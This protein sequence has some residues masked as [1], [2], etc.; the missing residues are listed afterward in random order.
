MLREA[1][2]ALADAGY[3]ESRRGRYGGTFVRADLERRRAARR[4]AAARRARRTCSAC[5]RVLEEGAVAAAAAADRCRGRSGTRSGRG[6]SRRAPPARPTTG[7]PTRGC[8][9]RSAELAGVPS[10]LPLLA[11]VRDRAN[12]LLDSIPLHR[13]EPRPLERA[14]RGDRAGGAPRRP[15]G[16]A[17]ARCGSTS[18]ARPPSS[19]R[20]STDPPR[21][22]ARSCTMGDRGTAS[23]RAP[24]PSSEKEERLVDLDA[25]WFDVNGMVWSRLLVWGVIARADRRRC[26]AAVVSRVFRAVAR[27]RGWPERAVAPPPLAVPLA[28]R[29]DRRLDRV[30]PRRRSARPGTPALRQ[31][32][33]RLLE[34]RDHRHGR[35]ARRGRRL[36]AG[37]PAARRYRTDVADNRVARRVR[38]QALILRRVADRGDRGRRDRAVAAGVPG[39]AGRRAPRC[40]PRPA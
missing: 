28:A 18:R 26:V 14:A 30:R 37:R 34:H 11:D 1:I 19:G 25:F 38:T 6:C 35:L 13:A 36:A 21:R 2:R 16:R 3:L 39:G 22:S 10:L 7:G 4:R 40:S 23:R 15:G 27:R 24:R 32:L 5:A 9:S 29:R 17:P 33:D 8:T 31:G 20:S 12:A